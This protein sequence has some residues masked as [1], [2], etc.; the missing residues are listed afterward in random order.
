[1]NERRAIGLATAITLLVSEALLADELVG[2][3]AS[4]DGRVLL[5]K[6][7]GYVPVRVGAKF[8]PGERLLVLEGA[9]ATLWY[10]DA[11]ELMLQGDAVFD[12]AS[13]STCAQGLGGEYSPELR[14]RLEARTR[15]VALDRIS[16]PS[17]GFDEVL[18]GLREFGVDGFGFEHGGSIA[19]A[20]GA[21]DM[22]VVPVKG[23]GVAGATSSLKAGVFLSGVTPT[24]GSLGG[25]AIAG[26]SVGGLSTVSATALA[27][28]GI[29]GAAE[30]LE[31]TKKTGD[32]GEPI[33]DD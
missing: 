6:E 18:G 14:E 32:G 4:V 1:M 15:K 11:C 2:E 13:Q 25:S 30:V 26:A 27:V 9:R 19:R 8:Y 5:A 22:G 16:A 7:T 33:S 23:V 31:R 20:A 24:A 21:T 29:V 28:S 3:F 12:I 10:D 17:G